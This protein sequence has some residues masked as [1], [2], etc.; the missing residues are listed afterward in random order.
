MAPTR[1]ARTSAK[2]QLALVCQTIVAVHQIAGQSVRLIPSVPVTR[3]VSEKGAKTLVQVL[4][5]SMLNVQ[6]ST[7]SPC[8]RVSKGTLA[9]RSV[10]AIKRSYLVSSI[11]PISFLDLSLTLENILKFLDVK[12]RYQLNQQRQTCAIHLRVDP[13]LSA[14]TESVHAW[15]ITTVIR[16]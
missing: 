10:S 12:S 14:T 7:T 16:L 2:L 15:P 11:L 1:F 4:A 6:C 5:V 9:I 3:H 8:A 13:T